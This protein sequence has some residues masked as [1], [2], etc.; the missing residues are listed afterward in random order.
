LETI[1]VKSLSYYLSAVAF[2]L[3]CTVA[4]VW[5]A[6]DPASLLARAK[7]AAGGEAVD[8]IRATNTHAKVKMGGLEGA[9]QSWEDVRT[10][11][12]RLEV[13]LGPASE[14]QGFDGTT[15][16]SL[17][18]AKQ[19]VKEEGDDDLK[20]NADDA[21]RR[22]MGYWYPERW[23]GVIESLGQRDES[24]RKFDVL[25]ITPKGGR[26]F[27]LWLDANT[28][29]IDRTIEKAETETH[30]T[31][32]SDYR[33]VQGAKMAFSLRITN[34]E[35]RYDQLLTVESITINPVIDAARFA[36][37]APPAPD[38]AIAG[39]S[40]ATV[41]FELLNNHTY[42]QVKV[43][44]KGPYRFL[45]D[46]GGENVITPELARA[47]DLKT[48]GALQGSGVGE[49]SEDVALTKVDSVALGGVTLSRQVFAVAPL[50]DLSAV[51]GVEVNGLV[52]YELFKRFVVKVDYANSL[53]TFTLPTAS[54]DHTAGIVV[55]FRFNEHIPQVDGEIDGIAGKFDIDTGSRSSLDLEGPF[56]EAHNLSAKYQPKFEATTGYGFGGASRSAVSRASLLKLGSV[57][58]RDPVTD[59]TLQ[60]KGSL[61][62]QYVAGNVGAGV[63]KRFNITFDYARQQ[64]IFERNANDELRDN[65]DRAGWW[66]NM[67]EGGFEVLDVVPGGPAA[68]AGLKV[69]DRILAV[70]GKPAAQVSLP[71]LRV[72]LRSDAPGS[73]VALR[74]ASGGTTREVTLTLRDLV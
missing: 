4:S 32:Y 73:K 71:D 49:K 52:G 55:P 20:G 10:G 62:S 25:R 18:S 72:R 37:P 8:R 74:I 65:F 57:E 59:L 33:E 12:F 28:S 30:T 46:T 44:G 23:P 63:L 58:V 6:D 47:L 9:A 39:A 40:S 27:E 45:C 69:G 68:E 36:M 2:V 11:S 61:T 19:P 38:F 14:A 3:L 22:T 53:L 41:P 26:P 35:T 56:I 34:G 21:Y 54:A 29:L 64:L 17:D 67:S 43:N 1:I 31:F 5:A 13:Q 24:G 7:Q 48:E 70:D 66:L 51:E 42:V 15:A 16:W 50:S 60:K